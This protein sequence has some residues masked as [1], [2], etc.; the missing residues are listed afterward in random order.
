M[1]AKPDIE[2]LKKNKAVESVIQFGSS[3]GKKDFRD[4]DLCI[5]TSRKLNLKEKLKLLRNLPEKYDVSFYEDLSLNIKKEVLSKGKIIFTNNY[6][7][8][9]KRIM[10]VELEYPRYRSFLEDYHKKRMV[11]A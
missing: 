9:L 4:I 11:A 8:L 5:F 3:V 2:E 1:E 6:Y 7:N 10:Y